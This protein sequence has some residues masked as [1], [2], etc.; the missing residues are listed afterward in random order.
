[1]Y[2]LLVSCYVSG[3]RHPARKSHL[4]HNM[5]LSCYLIHDCPRQKTLKVDVWD[6]LCVL[7]VIPLLSHRVF[8]LDLSGTYLQFYAGILR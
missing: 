6:C 1:M 3:A 5:L 4:A 2:I 8:G 7:Q